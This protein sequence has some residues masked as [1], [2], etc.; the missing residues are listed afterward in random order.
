MPGD[1]LMNAADL[2]ALSSLVQAEVRYRCGP[3]P[4]NH[5]RQEMTTLVL[6]EIGLGEVRVGRALYTLRRRI[7]AWVRFNGLP[8]A[9]VAIK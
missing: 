3:K 8:P 2:G 9:P 6:E 5:R 1:M 4:S 7:A